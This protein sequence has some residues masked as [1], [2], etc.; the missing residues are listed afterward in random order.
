MTSTELVH[1]IFNNKRSRLSE[2]DSTAT[3]IYSIFDKGRLVY[4]G[5]AE[6]AGGFRSRVR[7]QH[8]SGNSCVSS[9]CNYLRSEKGI[10]VSTEELKEFSDIEAPVKLEELKV[11][12]YLEN[13]VS[14]SLIEVDTKENLEDVEE[15]PENFLLNTYFPS[16]EHKLWNFATKRSE[17]ITLEEYRKRLNLSY[18]LIVD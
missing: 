15:F 12:N 17:K 14:V 4:V 11:Q 10:T 9:F 7:N 3:G 16:S 8:G 2:V 18:K 6:G 1:Q 5:K 13:N